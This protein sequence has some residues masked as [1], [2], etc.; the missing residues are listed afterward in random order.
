MEY[1]REIVDWREKK[2][3]LLEIDFTGFKGKI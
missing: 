1:D 2:K 3:K